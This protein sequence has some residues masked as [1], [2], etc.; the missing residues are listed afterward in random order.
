VQTRSRL[1]LTSRYLFTARD[2]LGIDHAQ[3]LKVIPLQSMSDADA[4]KLLLAAL[5]Q[6][7]TVLK[8]GQAQQAERAIEVARGHPLLLALLLKPIFAGDAHLADQTLQALA[9]AMAGKVATRAQ[10]ADLVQVLTRLAL[11]NYLAALTPD[12]LALLKLGCLFER[13]LQIPMIAW[14]AAANAIALPTPDAALTRLLALGLA[15]AGGERDGYAHAAITPMLFDRWQ[16]ESPDLAAIADAVFAALDRAWSDVDGDPPKDSRVFELWRWLLLLGCPEA[17]SV[18][19]IAAAALQRR[20]R[21]LH[22]PREAFDCVLEPALT[23]LGAVAP[24]YSLAIIGVDCAEL[25]GEIVMQNELL[26]HLAKLNCSKYEYAC[27]LLRQADQAGLSDTFRALALLDKASVL[28]GELGVERDVAI[29]K[30]KAAH[31]LQSRGDL[32]GALRTLSEQVLPIFQE[33]GM[34]IDIVSCKGQIA[35]IFQ[36]R[37]DLDRALKIRLNDQLPVLKKMGDVHGVAIT[38]LKIADIL[39]QRNDLEGALHILREVLPVF[40]K[41]GAIRDVANT[42]RQ[43][44]SVIF[45]KSRE[46]IENLAYAFATYV[47]LGRLADIATTGARFADLLDAQNQPEQAQQIRAQSDAAFAELRRQGVQI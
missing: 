29:A 22:Q 37:G 19:R 28:F 45:E 5:T 9:H 31:F 14:L 13:G 35:D 17:E 44:A 25:L 34:L 21:A 42:R 23:K 3:A 8:R 47:K 18:N 46:V 16:Q 39:R 11:D 10:P 2:A 41:L 43:L 15:E 7:D 27:I 30:S 26:S 24:S 38:N 40:E 20:Y 33:E 36:K 32:G 12:Q 4:R 1:L 6:R